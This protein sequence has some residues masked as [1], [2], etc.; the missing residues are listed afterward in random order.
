MMVQHHTEDCTFDEQPGSCAETLPALPTR[1]TE[2][3]GERPLSPALAFSE[4]KCARYLL[5]GA[6]PEPSVGATATRP[7]TTISVPVSE[8][9]WFSEG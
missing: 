1:A 9:L 4:E 6:H 8:V 7:V 5:P 3:S 2:H